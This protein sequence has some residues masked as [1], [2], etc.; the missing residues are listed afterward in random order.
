M[1]NKIISI[2]RKKEEKVFNEEVKKVFDEEVRISTKFIPNFNICNSL[3]ETVFVFKKLYEI[4][5]EDVDFEVEQWREQI[6][7][8]VMSYINIDSKPTF[9]EIDA[10][11]IVA[12]ILLDNN[13]IQEYTKF[14][15][16][17]PSKFIVTYSN[18]S[19]K[20]PL[21]LHKLACID[22][23]SVYEYLSINIDPSKLDI[24]RQR[25]SFK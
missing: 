4:D 20:T 18:N 19:E 13:K 22:L 3:E 7:E 11:L 21:I 17:C 14:I 16:N 1:L 25:Y 8:K 23:D 2:F 12:N 10:M 9:D 5:I 24:W 6:Y 15:F